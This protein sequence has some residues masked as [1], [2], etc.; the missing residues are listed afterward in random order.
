MDT[1]IPTPAPIAQT[2]AS[3]TMPTPP[4]VNNHSPFNWKLTLILL[5]ILGAVL[6]LFIGGYYFGMRQYQSATQAVPTV[7]QIA[8]PTPTPADPTSDWKT[9]TNTKYAFSIKYPS[10]WKLKEKTTEIGSDFVN[11]QSPN[12]YGLGISFQQKDDKN[13]MGPSGIAA[14]EFIKRGNIQFGETT[15]SKDV[16][17]YKEKDKQVWYNGVSTFVVGN[18]KFS[19]SLNNNQSTDYENTSLDKETELTTDQILSTFKFT[20]TTNSQIYTDPTNMYSFQLPTGW[21]TTTQI[22]KGSSRKMLSECNLYIYSDIYPNAVIA[23]D[24][25]PKGSDGAFCWSSGK[26]YDYTQRFA[27][28][29]AGP[30][31]IEVTKWESLV[32]N[33]WTDDYFQFHGFSDT[34]TNIEFGL[35]NQTTNKT[36]TEKAF[37]QILSTFKFTK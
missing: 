24:I 17:V 14:G 37:D 36:A 9:Y 33:V 3:D 27:D 11:F 12:G 34:K 28:V 25:S 20:D 22:P 4:P 8:K 15:I 32:T 19:I 10:T 31:K 23:V 18:T 5:G 29:A 16:L 30:I 21:Q 6:A 35:I 7:A 13:Q 2:T 1:T 26:F